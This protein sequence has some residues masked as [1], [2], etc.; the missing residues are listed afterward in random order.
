M[1][2]CMNNTELEKIMLSLGESKFRAKQLFEWFHQ[3]KIWDYNQMTNL[4]KNLKDK[5]TT[6]YP[7]NNIKIVEKYISA[8]DGT[9][10]YLFELSDY[11]IIE[12]VLM[13]YKHGNSVCISSQVG[14]RMG[15]KFCASTIGGLKRNLTPAEMLAQVYKISEDINEKI[16][17]IVIMGT[18]EPLERLDITTKFIEL[19]NSDKGQN[20]GQRHITV[21]T[22][23][24]VPKILELAE[25]EMQITL[26][27]SLHA[28]TDEDRKNIMPIANKYTI[29]QLLDAC[30]LYINKTGRRITFE[31][32]LIDGQNDTVDVAKQLSNLLKGMLCHVNL[33]PIN[34]IETQSFK[35][36]S[37]DK[38]KD[39][40][41]ILK[42]RGIEVTVRRTL[43]QDINASCGQLRYN[44]LKTCL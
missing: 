42:S 17:N 13:K 36:S 40:A 39:F 16:S 27:I 26:A 19:I 20:I 38:I 7:T 31:Y 8:I 18:G 4:P 10:K 3:K 28:T 24:L 1:L 37:E 32:S 15:C 43:G 30:K 14:C 21:S 34:K 22:C 33:I 44:Y 41:N 25:K 35:S 6:Q 29:K 12:S 2:T 11:H 23:G 5:L 9:R